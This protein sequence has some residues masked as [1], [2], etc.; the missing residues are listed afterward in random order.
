MKANEGML[1]P[2]A[3]VFLNLSP[4]ECSNRKK[5]DFCYEKLVSPT[6]VYEVYRKLRTFDWIVRFITENSSEKIIS[7]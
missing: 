5:F 2:D 4:L 1:A 7:F 3:V 6:K